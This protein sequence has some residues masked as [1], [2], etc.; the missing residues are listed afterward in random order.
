MKQPLDYWYITQPFKGELI[1]NGVD[2]RATVGTPIFNPSKGTVE[3]VNY[4]STGGN[5]LFIQHDNGYRTTYS[6]LSS[7]LVNP[8]EKVKRGQKIALTG[9]TGYTTGPHLHFTVKKDNVRID[10]ETVKFNKISKGGQISLITLGFL[11]GGILI[12]K[13]INE[14]K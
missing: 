8:G 1:H 9:N 10:P 14:K 11:I 3:S 7:T 2:L 13:A 6:H 4:N 12:Y 5:Q